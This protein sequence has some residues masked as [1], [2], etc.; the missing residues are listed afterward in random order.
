M[1]AISRQA[2]FFFYALL[3]IVLLL[4][5]PAHAAGIDGAQ[6]SVFW[7]IPFVCMLL[8]IAIF[9]LIMPSFWHHHFGKIAT[10]WGLAFL[11]PFAV[12]AGFPIAFYEFLH[13]MLTEYLPFIIVLFSLY[14]VAGGIRLKGSLAGTPLVNTGILVAG[15][16][17][18]SW[19]GTT[20]AAMLLIRPLLRANAHR[21]YQVH[22]VVFFIFLVANI[23]GSLTPLGD[24]PLFLGFLK[25]V[26]FFWT[27]THLFMPMLFV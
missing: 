13:A 7:V 27:L 19:M 11:L 2:R 9:P 26:P 1:T 21:R 15:A 16:L 24:P 8:S 20:G 12:K 17:L 22:S 18:A 4:P 23:G 10:G 5:M 25:G 3:S 14:T 6:F